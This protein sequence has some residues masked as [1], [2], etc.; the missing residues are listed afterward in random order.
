MPVASDADIRAAAAVL[1]PLLQL[2]GSPSLTWTTTS[3]RDGYTVSEIPAAPALDIPL[4]CF[5]T[6]FAV[7]A[8]VETFAHAIASEDAARK[9]DPTLKEIRILST[10]HCNSLLYTS[11]VSPA[12]W[13]VSPRDFCVTAANV[14]TSPDQLRRVCPQTLETLF[15]EYRRGVYGRSREDATSP[16]S[17]VFLQS[18]RSTPSPLCPPPTSEG[19]VTYIRGFV[20]CYGYIAWPC[21]G[22]HGTLQVTNFCCVDACGRVPKWLVA[23]AIDQNTEKLK[24]IAHHVEETARE[25]ASPPLPPPLPT[26]F[27]EPFNDAPDADGSRESVSRTLPTPP[28]PTTPNESPYDA[29]LLRVQTPGTM[30]S[31]FTETL[32]AATPTLSRPPSALP[33]APPTDPILFPVPPRT[34]S[35]S[36]PA[37]EIEQQQQQQFSGDQPMLFDTMVQPLALLAR[38]HGW[39]AVREV[40]SIDYAELRALPPSLTSRDG[41][42]VALRVSTT[43]TCSLDTIKELLRNPARAPEIDPELVRLVVAPPTPPQLEHNNHQPSIER[44][45]GGEGASGTSR[46]QGFKS[47]TGASTR[48]RCLMTSSQLRHLQFRAEPPFRHAWDVLL[49]CT[50]GEFSPHEGGQ[51]GFHTSGVPAST[52]VWMAKSSDG[53]EG[54][55]VHAQG[56]VRMHLRVFGVVVVAVPRSADAVRVTH[57]LLVDTPSLSSSSS[58]QNSLP[59]NDSQFAAKGAKKVTA[60]FLNAVSVWMGQRL[61]RLR[62][63][64]EAQQLKC[65]RDAMAPLDKEPLL[66]Y[67]YHIHCTQQAVAARHDTPRRVGDVQ[68]RCTEF[69][70]SNTEDSSPPARGA[71]VP[72]LYVF[73]LVFP[74]SLRH[75]QVYMNSTSSHARYAMD[76][77]IVLY[78]EGPSPPGFQAIHVEVTSGDDSHLTPLSFSFLETFGLLRDQDAPQNAL[79]LSRL[80]CD[81]LQCVAD[82]DSKEDAVHTGRIYC[83]GWVATPI[84]PTEDGAEGIDDTPSSSS[85]P[86]VPF[87]ASVV[88]REGVMRRLVAS[89]RKRFGDPP[90]VKDDDHVPQVVPST[91][92]RGTV[93]TRYVSL[94]TSSSCGPEAAARAE[95]NPLMMEREATV[96]QRFRDA[97]CAWKAD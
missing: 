66:R 7:H 64:C 70:G 85:P 59:R 57:Y 55:T 18:S 73:S 1:E 34:A 50:E 71:A 43:V 53:S 47:S 65:A 36:P 33:N 2:A 10:D 15:P 30:V 97:V 49:R 21:A 3:S 77:R 27:E 76:E 42:C 41:V 86:Y 9:C 39:H 93:V 35:S 69:P 5:R 92:T 16:S 51:L 87:S 94:C 38:A 17:M 96:L 20:H 91:V 74:C 6:Q 54:R 45:D 12:P 32:S 22:E 84:D 13:L 23:A 29:E 46:A 62:S 37:Q 4:K 67:L 89:A 60:S 72:P 8:D 19:T 61:C 83:S 31:A 48:G 56:F 78:E 68:V 28:P 90:N 81:Q 40:D 52:Y 14:L 63:Q 44:E 11:Y 75:L 58:S 25:Q 88:Q 26:A 24:R 80:N 95:R 82:T 79:V